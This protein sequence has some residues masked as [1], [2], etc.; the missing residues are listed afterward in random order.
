MLLYVAALLVYAA[1]ILGLTG[2]ALW[3]AV[4]GHALLAAWCIEELAQ[5]EVSVR[6]ALG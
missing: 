5:D 4:V 1:T 3:P 2:V 6:R